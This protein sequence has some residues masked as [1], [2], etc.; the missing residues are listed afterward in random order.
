MPEL[1]AVPG[2][3]AGGEI[4]L[5]SAGLLLAAVGLLAFNLGYVGLYAAFVP[6]LCV[7][8]LLFVEVGEDFFLSLLLLAV[9]GTLLYAVGLFALPL[10]V[11]S[12]AM[13][14]PLAV[15]LQRWGGKGLP[16]AVGRDPRPGWR[17]LEFLAVLLGALGARYVLYRSGGGRIP[18]RISEFESF[19]RFIIS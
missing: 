13:T 9:T 17:M 11:G 14:A 8:T 10:V 1:S 12:V 4:V 18:F 6:L 2:P 5:G 3:R 15:L 7:G 19:A 16:N